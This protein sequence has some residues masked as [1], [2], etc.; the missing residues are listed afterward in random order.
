MKL[1]NKSFLTR[2]LSG[3]LL[4]HYANCNLQEFAKFVFFLFLYNLA[5][6]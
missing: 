3:I 2:F 6:L 1:Y 5:G 4:S